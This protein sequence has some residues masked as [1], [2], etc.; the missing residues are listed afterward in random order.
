M[1]L[2]EYEEIP[3]EALNYMVAQANYGGRVT[4]AKDR[5][6]IEVILLDLYTAKV[7]DPNYKYSK[8]GIYSAPN[9]GFLQDYIDHITTLPIRQ[10]TEIFGLHPNAEITSAI[11][12]TDTIW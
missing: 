12:E 8:S 2:D 11:M 10:E 5:R 4:D 9:E 7:L 3:W 1:F 6:L